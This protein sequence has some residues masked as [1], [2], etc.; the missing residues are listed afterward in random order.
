MSAPSDGMSLYQR[1]AD[2]LARRIATGEFKP[3]DRLPTEAELVAQ[4]SVSRITIRQALGIL[5]ARGLLEGFAGRGTF[6]KAPREQGVWEL[7]SIA[8]V[9]QMSVDMKTR[10]LSWKLVEAPPLAADFFGSAGGVFRMQAVRTRKGARE[11]AYY[12]ENFTSREIGMQIT[13][14]DLGDRLMIDLIQNELGIPVER[15]TE[16]IG[17]G[18]ADAMLAGLLRT[19][20]GAPLLIQRIALS[21]SGGAPVAIGTTWWRSDRFTRR[22]VLAQGV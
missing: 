2:A 22:Y 10:V 9:M 18:T 4:L 16:E 17:A 1:I 14:R 7:R 19:E 11:P 21:G 20:E 8:D 3:G 5:K 6:V 15:A 12:A 13:R